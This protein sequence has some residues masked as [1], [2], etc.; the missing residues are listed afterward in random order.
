VVAGFLLLVLPGG[1]GVR[2]AFLAELM[3]PYLA[4]LGVEGA[5]AAAWASAFLLRLVWTVSEL[6]VSIIMYIAGLHRGRPATDAS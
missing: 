6:A 5:T 4:G 1:L 2:E 3:V